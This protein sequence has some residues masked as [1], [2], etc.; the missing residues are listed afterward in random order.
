M[1]FSVFSAGKLSGAKSLAT[2]LGSLEQLVRPSA[3]GHRASSSKHT[4]G[5]SRE[6]GPL[7]RLFSS[8]ETTAKC[9]SLSP[10][11]C[12]ERLSYSVWR[13]TATFQRVFSHISGP[14]A[15]SGIRTRSKHSLEEGGHRG[16]PSSKQGVRLLQPILHCSKEGL[17]V[18][19]DFRSAAIESLSH[20]SEVQSLRSGPR[21]GLSR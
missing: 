19:S 7:S 10:A 5:Q 17:G 21:T 15:G 6:T 8:L 3:S 2:F 20:A 9:I 16:G 4:R 11:D 12:R 18:A 14:R 1:F 13:S